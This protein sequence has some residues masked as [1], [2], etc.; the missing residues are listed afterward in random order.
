[1]CILLIKP[2]GI[3]LPNDEILHQCW[4]SNSNGGGFAFV[5][6]Q[7]VSIKKYM[8]E[9][10][11]MEE[12]NAM[13]EQLKNTTALLHFRIATH[14]SAKIDNTHPFQ[15]NPVCAMGHN[16]VIQATIPDKDDGDISDT[17]KFAEQ[18]LK[19]MP[20]GWEKNKGLTTMLLNFVRYN[21]VGFIFGDDTYI[22]LNEK[23]GYWDE[24]IWYSNK[25]YKT[26]RYNERSNN[27]LPL[28]LG[29]QNNSNTKTH[30]HGGKEWNKDNGKD[31]DRVDANRK[32]LKMMKKDRCIFCN[33]DMHE[34]DI[35]TTVTVPLGNHLYTYVLDICSTCLKNMRS[36]NESVYAFAEDECECGMCEKT[37]RNLGI[38]YRF[39]T[40]SI[41]IDPNDE[42]LA[43]ME[44]RSCTIQR[45]N[46]EYLTKSSC[47][48]EVTSGMQLLVILRAVPI[49]R[50]SFFGKFVN[51]IKED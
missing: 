6:K 41:Y 50:T 30:G 23:D 19:T 36:E 10:A 22:I 2:K 32:V 51:T 25:S 21:K 14:G 27:Q 48:V 47:L 37:A 9:T 26:W 5:D 15:I 45:L 39:D 33:S 24:G 17:R 29:N 20:V 1:M 44:C 11:M 18:I 7:Q 13:R 38:R 42:A 35:K 34:Y 16:G 31:K 28:L 8:D 40:L 46:K 49:L 3:D 43:F 4:V 12:L